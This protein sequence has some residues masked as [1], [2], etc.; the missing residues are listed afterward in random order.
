MPVRGQLAQVI[1]RHERIP[2]SV[3]QSREPAILPGIHAEIIIAFVYLV[4]IVYCIVVQSVLNY[5]S[6]V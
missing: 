6:V 2:E 5:K 3:R 1:Q 4:T